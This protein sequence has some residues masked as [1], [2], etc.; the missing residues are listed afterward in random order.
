VITVNYEDTYTID[1][2]ASVTASSP[3][4]CSPE[5]EVPTVGEWGL[6]I[7]GL[8]MSITAV[9]GIRQRREEEAYS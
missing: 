2:I 4:T 6:I 9:V 8:L 5:A 7:L 3:P 1:C